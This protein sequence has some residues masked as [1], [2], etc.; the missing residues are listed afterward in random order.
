LVNL[1]VPEARAKVVVHSPIDDV[2]LTGGCVYALS[3]STNTLIEFNPRVA[4]V[5]RRWRLAAGAQS[6]TSAG[7]EVYVAFGGSPAAVERFDLRGG[8]TRRA[9]I[10]HASGLAQDRAVAAG[11]GGLWV[12]DGGSIYRLDPLSLAVQRSWT[13]AASDIWFGDGSLW[14]ASENPNGGVERIDPA[15]GRIVARVDSDAIQMAFT[16]RAVWLSAAAGPTAIDPVTAKREATLPV[17]KVVTNGASGIAVVGD[18]VWT[19]YGDVSKLQR[20]LPSPRP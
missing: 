6:L 2:V 10:P 16:P 9:A 5:T 18:Q 17:A 19:V 8:A 12:T 4:K 15:T 20:V 13:L 14:A 3:A 11:R 7:D 1:S